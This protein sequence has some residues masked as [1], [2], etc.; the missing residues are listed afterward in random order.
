MSINK[1]QV[2]SC[3]AF[4]T[5]REY[6]HVTLTTASL[7]STVLKTRQETSTEINYLWFVHSHYDLL[8]D[9]FFQKQV[10]PVF[11]NRLKI[12]TYFRCKSSQVFILHDHKVFLVI[13]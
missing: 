11:T 7:L 12:L 9:R 1:L 8:A 10:I 6:F 5:R 4:K 2:I 3:L 13:H